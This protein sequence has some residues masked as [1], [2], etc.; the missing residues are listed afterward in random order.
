M[1]FPIPHSLFTG[2]VMDDKFRKRILAFY[3]AAF[4][5]L[6][7]GL[8]VLFSGRTLVE[9]GMWYLLLTF[10]FGFAVVD[11]WFARNLKKKWIEAYNQHV[12]QQQS[13]AARPEA[14]RAK[15]EGRR[16]KEKGNAPGG[17]RS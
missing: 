8:Y 12:A 15:D 5:N 17:G 11:I 14:A 4:L 3:F 1:P 6:M 7:L 2:F 9:Q 13:A 10:F 16:M